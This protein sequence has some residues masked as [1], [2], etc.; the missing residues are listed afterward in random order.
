MYM[1]GGAIYVVH[2]HTPHHFD[3]RMWISRHTGTHTYNTVIMEMGHGERIAV[4]SFITDSCAQLRS[5]QVPQTLAYQ[6]LCRLHALLRDIDEGECPRSTA[7]DSLYEHDMIALLASIYNRNAT[8]ADQQVQQQQQQQQQQQ[9]RNLALRVIIACHTVLGMLITPYDMSSMLARWLAMHPEQ[10]DDNGNALL[11]H[12]LLL[13]H[14]PRRVQTTMVAFFE[15][16]L[17][18]YAQDTALH[19]AVVL[20]LSSMC[21]RNK[22]PVMAAFN[23]NDLHREV[24]SAKNNLRALPIYSYARASVLLHEYIIYALMVY[25]EEYGKI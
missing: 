13:L 6:S 2:T 23:L 14:S 3:T 22:L 17:H 25:G 12:T 10:R 5:P 20:F 24:S 19:V 7:V 8:G 1:G 11:A 21:V 4:A 18:N 16:V 15:H 9:V